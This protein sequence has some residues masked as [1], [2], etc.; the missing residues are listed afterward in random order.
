VNRA[1]FIYLLQKPEAIN[2]KQTDAIAHIIK[3][4]PYFQSARSLY[5]KGLKNQDSYHYNSE[6][7]VTAAHT[8]DRSVLFDFIT[9]ARFNQNF[10]SKDMLAL[11][12]KLRSI[13]VIDHQEVKGYEEADFSENKAVLDPT[14]FQP[15]ETQKQN[16][17]ATELNSLNIEKP[18]D[19][20]QGER[21]S[22]NEWL[23]L[24]SLEPVMRE[25]K[26]QP[27]NDLIDSF[28]AKKPKI[29]PPTK[30]GQLKNLAE[31]RAINT[32]ELMTETLA[33]VYIAQKNF[34]KA[35]QAY[36]ILSL[37]YPEKSSL[38]ADRIKEIKKI[39]K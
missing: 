7:K 4:F 37:K 10:I 12:E 28:L 29:K 39:N 20:D 22:F 17:K 26:H 34:D 27:A 38:F 13:N 33:N 21:H 2:Q 14:L 19:F 24:T 23:K 3:E 30:T 9:S 15:K 6:L 16:A 35:I 25:K 1:D 36:K 32:A 18:L 31:A 5:L 8:T 11:E